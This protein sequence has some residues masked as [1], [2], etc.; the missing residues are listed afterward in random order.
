MRV[1]VTVG[2]ATGH[3]RPYGSLYP[4]TF[5]PPFLPIL[6]PHPYF[7]SLTHLSFLFPSPTHSSHTLEHV[8]HYHT[9]AH[10]KYF[11]PSSTS[12]NRS[13]GHAPPHASTSTHAQTQSAAVG[14]GTTVFT[15]NPNPTPNPSPPLDESVTVVLRNWRT[16]LRLGGVLIVSVP[17]IVTLARM[18][19]HSASAPA[20]VTDKEKGGDVRTLLN[21]VYGGQD[22][23]ANFHKTGEW[24]ASG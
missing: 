9:A 16:V 23:A 10:D 24:G 3:G 6:S 22:Y 12:T 4:R 18:I 13:H 17:D 8:S 19:V 5:Y 21:V 20:S 14:N 2:V 11:Y 15:P 7:Y 1:M